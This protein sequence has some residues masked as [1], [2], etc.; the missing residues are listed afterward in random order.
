MTEVSKPSLEAQPES[1]QERLP[2]QRPVMVKLGSLRDVTQTIQPG[3]K[4]DGK[5]LRNT[6]RGGDF[7]A[8][9]CGR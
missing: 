9:D 2:Y 8:L 3:T 4:N 5:S 7:R 6:S 1:V